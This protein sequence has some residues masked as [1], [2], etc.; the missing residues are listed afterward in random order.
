MPWTVTRQI[1]W[2]S[3]DAVVEISKG[4]RDY[5]NP[6]ALSGKY[7]GEFE[8]FADPE[9]AA[10]VALQILDL[11]QGDGQPD[12]QVAYG[13]TGG[14]TM[15]F[16]P[17]TPDELKEWAA[18]AA[19]GLPKCDHCGGI[20]GEEKYQRPD[21]PDMTYCR[22]Y[23]AEADHEEQE[24]QE[25]RE[26]GVCDSCRNVAHDSGIQ[27]VTYQAG[28]MAELGADLEDHLCDSREEPSLNIKCLCACNRRSEAA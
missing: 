11:W 6:D 12:A 2:P 10:Q 13:A 8:T 22:E 27:G 1:Q 4:G 23:C 9:E 17:C 15:P 25:V 18:K 7:P 21:L 16:S 24:R 14:M 5:T 20:L 19:E 26:C 3:G 28:V